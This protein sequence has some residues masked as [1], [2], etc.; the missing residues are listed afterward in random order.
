MLPVTLF[1]CGVARWTCGAPDS[2]QVLACALQAVRRMPQ[3]PPLDHSMFDL[4]LLCSA[5][6][7]SDGQLSS[8]GG[9]QSAAGV[10]VVKAENGTGSQQ[11]G[12]SAAGHSV[13][14]RPPLE[15]KRW[16]AEADAA[17]GLLPGTGPW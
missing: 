4:E 1:C 7:G 9:Q 17:L 16:R 6:N 5:A 10:A 15:R 2:H 8:S 12:T 11:N 3:L 13:S 14:T